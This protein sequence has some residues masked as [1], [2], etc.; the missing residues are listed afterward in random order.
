MEGTLEKLLLCC[1][2]FLLPG[3]SWNLVRGLTS[4][5]PILSCS[6]QP[7]LAGPAVAAALAPPSGGRGERGR[8]VASEGGGALSISP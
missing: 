4:H 3:L 8:P 5:S 7:G 6:F 2:C 1:Q